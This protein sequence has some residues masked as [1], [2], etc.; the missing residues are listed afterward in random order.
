[1]HICTLQECTIPRRIE[2]KGLE[3]ELRKM[4]SSLA[5]KAGRERREMLLQKQAEEDELRKELKAAS[6]I[7]DVKKEDIL[8]MCYVICVTA[9]GSLDVFA[10]KCVGPRLVL[11]FN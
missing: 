4:A 3:G 6:L 7:P 11:G 1:M 10:G 5:T 9:C 8:A 2:T